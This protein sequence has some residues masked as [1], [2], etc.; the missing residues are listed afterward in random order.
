VE[1]IR[2]I[3]EENSQTAQSSIFHL[4]EFNNGIPPYDNWNE[5]DR[6]SFAA[7]LIAITKNAI[8]FGSAHSVVVKD[9]NEVVVPFFATKK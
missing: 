3:V 1:E 7:D 6:M 2:V 8:A 5:D 9:W 4:T